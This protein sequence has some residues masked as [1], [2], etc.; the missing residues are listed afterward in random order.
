MNIYELQVSHAIGVISLLEFYT[1]LP[2]V[3]ITTTDQKE[4]TYIFWM[5]IDW[6]KKLEKK[7]EKNDSN[8]F[9]PVCHYDSCIVYAK[10]EYAPS[11]LRKYIL[12]LAKNRPLPE[13]LET[14]YPRQQNDIERT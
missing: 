6:E 12:P 13:N 11:I 5:I 14:L 7:L 3:I 4:L 8:I 9:A 2:D 1:S 10:N